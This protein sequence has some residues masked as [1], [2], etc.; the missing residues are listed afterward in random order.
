M[1]RQTVLAQLLVA[2]L[3]L[4]VRAEDAPAPP[5][6]ASAPGRIEVRVTGLRNA[7]GQVFVALWRS[8]KKFPGTPPKGTASRVVKV[9]RDARGT[10]LAEARF[11]EVPPGEFAI[12][13]F[14]DEDSDTELE[15]NFIGIP[16]EGIGFSRDARAR[17]GAPDYEAAKLMLAPG[18][19]EKLTITMWY[20]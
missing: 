1:T 10:P 14:H 18:E 9:A 7:R 11:D 4:T 15:T 2:L 20:L 19:V 13:V 12:T 16:R 5:L 17:I 8:A 3:S 6:R